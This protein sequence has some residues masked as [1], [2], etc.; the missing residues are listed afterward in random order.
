ME[1]F[2]ITTERLGLRRFC[3]EDAEDFAE[4]LTDD[5]VSYFEP[6]DTF[7][8]EDAL[9]EAANIAGD[10]RFF[11]VVLRE[12]NKLIGKVYFEDQKFFGTYEIGYSFNRSF[13]GKGYA[14]EAACGVIKYG[15]T[16]LN[17]R[18]IIAEADV[19][20]TR[21]LKLLDSAGMRRE[22]VYI[23]SA[24]FQ[25]DENGEPLYSDYVTFAI[26]RDEWQE[27]QGV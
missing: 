19:R 11:A 12:S 27:R 10:E 9:K 20:N 1:D 26:L 5:V 8:R 7:S 15:F 23:K 3:V 4:I 16:E 14:L 18:R 17:V 24:S 6:Y 13:W 2:I 21:S 22:G 25:K